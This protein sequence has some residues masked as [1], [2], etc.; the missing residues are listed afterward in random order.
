MWMRWCRAI[1]AVL[2]DQVRLAA[3][4][5]ENFEHNNGIVG[6]GGGGRNRT[7]HDD[8]VGITGSPVGD[9]LDVRAE[10]A[11]GFSR[12]PRSLGIWLAV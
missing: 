10:R 8:R 11:T 12:E 6:D 2:V 4:L 1:F 9:D 3:A 5:A 7:V